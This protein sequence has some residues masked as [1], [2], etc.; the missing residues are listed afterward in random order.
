MNKFNMKVLNFIKSWI[1]DIH[2]TNGIHCQKSVQ[3]RSLFWSVFSCIR[4]EYGVFLRKSP[5][6]VQ[7]QENTD[8]QKLHI[9]TFFSLKLLSHLNKLKSWHNSNNTVDSMCTCAVSNQTTLGYLLRY[10]FYFT[11]SLE[12]GNDVC[13]FITHSH[14]HTPAHAILKTKVYGVRFPNFF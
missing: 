7:I 10:N 11:H 5:Y 14:S 3:I 8:Q 13:V 12:Y 2:D 1:F 4:T 6:S 9:W